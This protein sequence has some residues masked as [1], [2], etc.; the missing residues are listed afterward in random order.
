MTDEQQIRQLLARWAQAYDDRD[1]AGWTAPFVENG[2]FA[3]D[4]PERNHVGRAE[5]R[6][7][8]DTAIANSPTDRRTKHK[9]A[10]PVIRFTGPDA[11]DV[12]IDFVVY[13]ARGNDP[14]GATSIGRY[15][16]KLVRQNGEWYF[17]EN[18]VTHP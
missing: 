8:I 16:N 13:S 18:F 1:A 12:N 6:Q 10:N 17:L 14:W 3:V 7:Y 5:I 9:C 4:R 2:R 11:A 15:L